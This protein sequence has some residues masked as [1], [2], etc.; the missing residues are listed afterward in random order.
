MASYLARYSML[1]SLVFV[2]TLI[3][4]IFG[5]N[6][7]KLKQICSKTIDQRQCMRL[8][9]SDSRTA[10]TNIR[11]LTEVAIDLAYR[12]AKEIH[13]HLNSRDD[14]RVIYPITDGFSSSCA[15]NYQDAIRDLEQTR[16][17]FYDGDYKR[18]VVQV[19]DA[20]EEVLYCK[21]QIEISA[22]YAA[23][24]TGTSIE[25]SAAG[26]KFWNK[27]FELL[28]DVVKVSSKSLS[29]NSYSHYGGCFVNLKEVDEH[30]MG[31][32]Y[33]LHLDVC[34]LSIRLKAYRV[35]EGT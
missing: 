25:N 12:K 7:N 24:E 27:E 35:R 6:H 30:G 4:P 18:I 34:S 22:G 11:R 29:D 17:L 19:N 3:G 26:L 28:C 23:I 31:V 2:F 21:N 13:S 14:K 8:M 20:K 5:E 10:D 32:F 9:K 15:K 1:V 16:K 33:P